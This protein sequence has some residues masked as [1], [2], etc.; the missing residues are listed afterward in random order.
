M[1]T[2]RTFTMIKP[3]AVENGHTGAILEKINAAGFRIVA[4]KKTQM[5]K[6]DAETF[7]GVHSER[8]FFGELVE[9]MTRGPIIAAIL[10]KDNAVE[11]FRTL[12]GAT[13][14]AEAAEGT[15]RQLYATSIG[16]NAVHGSDSD[17]NAAIE[18]AFHFSGRE[19]F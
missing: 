16:E 13:N 12:I 6:R 11:D 4:M 7:Y 1:A 10:E 3:D 2:N 14:P 8:P 9:F 15:I 18:G 19:M 17:E 5:T